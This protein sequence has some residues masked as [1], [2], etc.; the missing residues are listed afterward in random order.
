MKEEPQIKWTTLYNN[1]SINGLSLRHVFNDSITNCL[2]GMGEMGWELCTQQIINMDVVNDFQ[3]PHPLTIKSRPWKRSFATRRNGVYSSK[4][5]PLKA[6]GI[7]STL[8][9]HI[10]SFPTFLDYK[11]N[12]WAHHIVIRSIANSDIIWRTNYWV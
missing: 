5:L 11:H 6:G 7:I 10:F 1:G 3:T 9:N 4:K 8:D 2:K 12:Q